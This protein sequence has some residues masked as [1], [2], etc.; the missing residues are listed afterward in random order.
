MKKSD[1]DDEWRLQTA[2]TVDFTIKIVDGILDVNNSQLLS[3]GSQGKH[4]RRI[5]IVDRKVSSFY[6]NEITN[7]FDSHN[8]N[9]HL[10]FI[11]SIEQNKNMKMLLFLLENIER[12]GLTRKSEPIIAIG[13]GVLLDIVGLAANLYRRGVPYIKV[14]TTLLSLVDASVGVKT[15]INFEERR[16]RLG[17]YHPPAAVYC[18]SYF[19]K[20]LEPIETTSGLGEIFKMAIVKDIKL[21]NI[22]KNDSKELLAKKFLNCRSS[23][24]VIRRSIKGMKD[25]LQ[26]NLWEKNLERYVDF[27][28]SFSPIPEI[29]SLSE[30]VET[31]THGQA[32]ALDVLF[33]CVISNIRGFL[34]KEDVF[35]IMLVAKDMGLPTTHEYFRDPNILQEALNDTIRHRNGSQNLPIPIEIGRSIFINNLTF[36]DIKNAVLRMKELNNE[37]A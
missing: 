2:L 32:V 31:L 37:F 9:Y 13:G 18:D 12:F 27:G 8:V 35:S 19:L 7:Y 22:L 34:S 33:S 25:E 5:V 11:D 26:D 28:H 21:F 3:I 16:N 30:D 29:R 10:L 36:D 24:E 23:K 1:L 6:L 14:P 4:A 17:T 20:T 15:G